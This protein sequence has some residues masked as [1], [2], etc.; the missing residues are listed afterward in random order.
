MLAACIAVAA[1]LVVSGCGDDNDSNDTSGAGQTTSI[2]A[3]NLKQQC[4]DAA[5]KLPD[6]DQKE[7]A[8]QGCDQ[9][10][11]AADSTQEARES[12]KKSCLEAAERL[13]SGE[14]RSTAEKRC[15]SLTE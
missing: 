7:A 13:P 4:L 11:D 14:T 3:G 15:N 2:D 1:V 8:E 12:I 6:G 10:G 5:A 9:V